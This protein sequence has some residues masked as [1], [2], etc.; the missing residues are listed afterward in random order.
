MGSIGSVLRQTLVMLYNLTG[1][2]GIAII[3]LTVLIRLVLLP[4]TL[5]QTRSVA[6]MKE[7]QPKMKAL[8]EKYKD[9]PDEYQRRMMELYKEHG[10]NPLSG[11]LPLLIQLPFL[12]AL[13]GV[14]R[15]FPSGI[16]PEAFTRPFESAFLFW[17]LAVKDPLY[18]L[19]ILSGLTTYLQMST[20]ATDPSQKSMMVFMPIFITWISLSFP[21]GLVLYWIVSNVLTIAQQAWISRHPGL[22][23]GGSDAK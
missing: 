20:A 7:L 3:T 21:A 17:D 23:Q 1:N 18:I 19:P 15:D 22:K 11:C 2:H 9:K 14:L 13:F 5:S 12:W 4:L 6:A 10:V 8:E 16:A